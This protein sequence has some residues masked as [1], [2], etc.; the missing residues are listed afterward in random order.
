MNRF[1]WRFELRNIYAG[2]DLDLQQQVGQTVPWY[3]YDT[4][5]TATDPIYDVGA[6]PQGRRWYPPL[7]LPALSVVKLEGQQVR[8]D[9]GFYVTDILRVV[10]SPETARL[11]GLGDL[12][13]HPDIHD[14]DR[15]VYENKVFSINQ[16][17]IKG[18]VT[19]GYAIGVA[20][21][22]Q[23]KSEELVNDPQFQTY[24]GQPN[25]DGI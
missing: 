22:V 18:V 3:L 23:V 8:N 11:V 21:A 4:A 6:T 15:I 19:A 7:L 5:D 2:Q 24:I 9:E 25:D 1:D 20:D 14:K 16:V 17:R 13:L 12:I 10:F